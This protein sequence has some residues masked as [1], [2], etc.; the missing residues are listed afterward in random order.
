VS[1]DLRETNLLRD[2]LLVTTEGFTGVGGIHVLIFQWKTDHVPMS[3]PRQR[4][5]WGPFTLAIMII[6]GIVALVAGVCAITG[7]S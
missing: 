5:P 7:I 6:I 3:P 1:D 2:K 4:P